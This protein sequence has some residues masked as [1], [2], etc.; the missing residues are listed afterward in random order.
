MD[1]TKKEAE[2]KELI[3]EI[4][5]IDFKDESFGE[6]SDDVSG[7]VAEKTKD[8]DSDT[9]NDDETAAESDKSDKE[10]SEDAE[11]KKEDKETSKEEETKET[12][13]EEDSKKDNKTESD[14][15]TSP[16]EV[17]QVEK[18][19]AEIERLSGL[20]PKPVME[21]SEEDKKDEKAEEVVHDFLKGMDMDDVS[22]DPAVFNKILLAVAAKV[23]QQTT[24]QV[25]RSIPQVV[26]S[27]VQ[28]QT[29][30][31]RMADKFYD[32]NKDL[33]NVKQVVRA[34]AQQIQ[35]NNPEWEIDKVFSEAAVKTRQT[36]GLTAPVIGETKE[37]ETVG[38]LDDAAF[39][40]SKGGS[41]SNL[42]PKRSSLQT[43][44]DEL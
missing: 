41:K 31:K 26:V 27:Q 20:V 7:E 18:L 19:L 8:T 14:R 15:E 37:A 39:A 10:E 21:V 42:K 17:S 5:D 34:C 3:E 30:F 36:L 38:N 40:K 16:K 24:E 1:D 23:Q 25:L 44:I 9:S 32:D 33:V 28:Q 13:T 4:A 2:N 43:E 6:E 29:Y 35:Q 11:K 22:S 12:E